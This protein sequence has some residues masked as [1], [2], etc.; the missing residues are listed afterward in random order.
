MPQRPGPA[1]RFGIGPLVQ[2]GQ[3][4]PAP[5]PALP[6]RPEATHSALARLEPSGRPF[7]LRLNRFFWSDGEAGFRRY[8]DLA[9]R[10]TGRG[11]PVE[12]QV[13]YHPDDP[14]SLQAA[15]VPVLTELGV[16]KQ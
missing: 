12:L 3:I 9:E 1:L 14:S 6:E 7:V 13:R 15:L 8:L 2:A 4:G 10:F 16:N 5:S 11:H